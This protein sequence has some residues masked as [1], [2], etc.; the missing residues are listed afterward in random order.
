[1][2][3]A[4]H[5]EHLGGRVDAHHDAIAADGAPQRGK[6][7]AGAAP[8]IDHHSAR[9]G[10]ELRDG[11]RVQRLVVGESFLPAGGAPTEER[12]RALKMRL[13]LLHADH[14]AGGLDDD[15][16]PGS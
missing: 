5:G 13:Q 3:G 15:Q 16:L 4:R 12:S 6:R 10:P 1:V 14:D 7:A 9:D 2:L 8:E 11:R